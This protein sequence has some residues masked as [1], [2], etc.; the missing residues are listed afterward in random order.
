MAGINYLDTIVVRRVT[1]KGTTVVRTPLAS[2]GLFNAAST[3]RDLD[4]LKLAGDLMIMSAKGTSK[5]SANSVG[6]TT[7]PD[8]KGH[9]ISTGKGTGRIKL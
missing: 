6:H 9:Y 5:I 4:R 3:Q 2:V 1:N 7:T 8:I